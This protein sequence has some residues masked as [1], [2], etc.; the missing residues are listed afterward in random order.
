MKS[1]ERIASFRSAGDVIVGA[2]LGALSPESL[3]AS[4]GLSG[5]ASTYHAISA[6]EARAV[7]VAVIHRDMAYSS[8]IVPHE[9]AVQLA[10]EFVAELPPASRFYTNGAY[11]LP[12][13]T[14][15][16]GPSWQP[17]TDATFDTGVLAIGVPLSACVW[18]KDED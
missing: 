11:G 10:R 18:F 7:L 4:F 3:A 6:E 12:H 5:D 13:P 9:I 8:E 17:A 15:G 2:R 16:V 14:V 1:L